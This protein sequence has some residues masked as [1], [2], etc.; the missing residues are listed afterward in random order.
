M[1]GR[2]TYCYYMVSNGLGCILDVLALSDWNI[3][4]AVFILHA[5]LAISERSLGALGKGDLDIYDLY[6]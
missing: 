6:D 1:N 4:K 3:E 2:S 5:L